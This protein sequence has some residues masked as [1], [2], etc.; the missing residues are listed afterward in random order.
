MKKTLILLSIALLAIIGYGNYIS[1]QQKTQPTIEQDQVTS[2]AQVQTSIYYSDNTANYTTDITV[3]STVLS[4]LKTIASD[5]QFEI[6]IQSFDFGD[7]VQGING[8]LA[9]D[10]KAW[11]YYVNGQAGDIGADQKPVLS[12]DQIEWKYEDIIY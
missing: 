10:E 5:Y 2:Q 6:E 8:F 7:L 11:I 9:S 1:N 4:V 12:E 3:D